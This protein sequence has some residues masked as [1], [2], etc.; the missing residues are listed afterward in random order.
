VP[1]EM[2]K[3]SDARDGQRDQS[4]NPDPCIGGNDRNRDQNN[5]NQNIFSESTSIVTGP[6][7]T[8]STSIMA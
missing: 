5:R 8:S 3:K 1:E 4:A 2:V 6:A 7:F